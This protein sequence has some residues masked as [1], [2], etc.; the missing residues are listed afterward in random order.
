MR[1][2]DPN[3]LW[4]LMAALIV[5]F[6]FIRAASQRRKAMSKLGEARLLEKL[7]PTTSAPRRR[8]KA[9]LVVTATALIA[10][11]L[12]RPQV[13]AGLREVKTSG[14]DMV[15]ILDVSNSMLAQD[16]SPSRLEAAKAQISGLM[17]RMKGDRAG[18]VVFA[19]EAFIQCPLTMDYRAMRMLLDAVTTDSVPTPGTNIAAALLEAKR[20]FKIADS[21]ARIAILLTDGEDHSGRAV[22]AARELAENKVKVFTI[23]IG[24]NSAS[25]APIPIR[26]PDGGVKYK[27]DSQGNVI[28]TRLDE[29]TLRKIALETGGKYYY[30]GRNLDLTRIYDKIDELKGK[31]SKSRFYTEY[32]DRFQWLLVPAFLI[33]AAEAFIPA[34]ARRNKGK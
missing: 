26:Q 9:V 12:A 15:F 24:D 27:K 29:E 4:A 22:Q 14:R 5:M 8:L 18:L 34:T 28:M 19:G 32:E 31:K 20:V 33:L 2:A 16:I 11:S 10:L 30:A 3:T 13:G 23:G 1:W 21:A 6:L 17:D 7:A 25:G